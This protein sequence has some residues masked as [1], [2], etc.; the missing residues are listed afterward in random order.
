MT[1][2]I[3]RLLAALWLLLAAAAPA[4]AEWRRAESPNFIAFSQ[5]DGARLRARVTMLEDYAALLR[6]LSGA[7]AESAPA[8][9][10]RVYF[11]RRPDDI[12]LVPPLSIFVPGFY[13][14]S[15][16]G[17]AAFV[18]AANPASNEIL[19]HEYAHHFMMQYHAGAYPP[20]YVEGFAEYLGPTRF[21]ERHIELGRMNGVRSSWLFQRSDWL[22]TERV[23]FERDRLKDIGDVSRFYAQSWLITHYLFG[24]E[25][26]RAQLVRYLQALGRGQEPPAAFQASFG[27]TP[28]EMHHRLVRYSR[29][30]IVFRRIERA[31]IGRPVEIAVTTLP[32]S[33]DQLLVAEA[34][35]LV[36]RIPT[37]E[38]LTR[39]RR[40]AA[41]LDDPYARRVL[42][43]AEALHGDGATAE[44]LL[45]GLIEADPNDAE[46]LYLRGMRHLVASRAVEG[47]ER[48]AQFRQA[49]PWFTRAH[50]ADPA[51]MPSLYRYVQTFSAEPDFTTD[52]NT[53]AMLLAVQLAPQVADARMNAA[54]MLLIRREF[55]LA[56]R[57]LQPLAST[58]HSG[59]QADAARALLEQVRARNAEGVEL[60]FD[61]PPE[62]PREPGRRGRD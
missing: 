23:L 58:A 55:E 3:F 40:D 31:S 52:N 45:T 9:K 11:V 62:T 28:A 61:Q 24:N 50:R 14:S 4:A 29:E 21:T 48:R 13:T 16:S 2:R 56:E 20:W 53:N 46:L 49:R 57:M 27:M 18:N 19:F 26:R 10:L 34:A 51:H 33:A 36:G 8:P 6:L 43:R 47:D 30:G 1:G 59:D 37:A 54:K 44:R 17:T 41:R 35:L 7:P 25:A 32:A 39:M 5:E 38:Q 15:S 22:P 12:A 60:I 42:A